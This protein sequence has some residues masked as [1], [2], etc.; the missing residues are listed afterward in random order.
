MS[1]RAKAVTMMRVEA[2]ATVPIVRARVSLVIVIVAA[3]TTVT[4][5]RVTVTVNLMRLIQMKAMTGN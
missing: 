2:I 5:A 4:Q 1:I 3:M